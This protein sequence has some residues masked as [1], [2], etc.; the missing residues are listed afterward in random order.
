MSVESVQYKPI[1]QTWNGK[2]WSSRMLHEMSASELRRVIS[3]FGINAI[4]A[5]CAITAARKAGG[6]Q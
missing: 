1:P 2:I 4:N 6:S 5:Q 3:L